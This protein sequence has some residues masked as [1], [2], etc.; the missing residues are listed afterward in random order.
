MTFE[1]SHQFLIKS[2][3]QAARSSRRAAPRS[4][5]FFQLYLPIPIIQSSTTQCRWL[6][7]H[8]AT[9]RG[10][11]AAVRWLGVTYANWVWFVNDDDFGG[12]FCLK[13][14]FLLSISLQYVCGTFLC[15]LQLAIN[16]SFVDSRIVWERVYLALFV[17]GRLLGT[18]CDCLDLIVRG[19][20]RTEFTF[21]FTLT[22]AQCVGDTQ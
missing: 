14:F 8:I 17:F 18:N 10:R 6:S 5:T 12:I 20:R 1:K 22:D 15:D 21:T 16:V 9:T 2:N 4:Q 7:Y 13:F 3:L 19:R 11:A